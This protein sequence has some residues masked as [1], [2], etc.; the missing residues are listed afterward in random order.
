MLDHLRRDVDRFGCSRAAGRVA[1]E[2]EK[3]VVGILAQ[4]R[5]LL[6]RE[7][8]AERGD[9]IFEAGLMQRDAVE[10]ALDDDQRAV[11][12]APLAARR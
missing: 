9:G 8:G 2:A 1:V 3:H 12:P 10:V 6:W 11:V 5:R 4:L 7:R